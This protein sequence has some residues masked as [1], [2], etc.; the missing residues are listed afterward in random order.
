[1]EPPH[2]CEVELLNR[3]ETIIDQLYGFASWPPTILAWLSSTSKKPQP[4]LAELLE[5]SN[6]FGGSVTIGAVVVPGVVGGDGS[7]WD[8]L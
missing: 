7:T 8:T 6:T 3:S 5:H 1:M 4:H 2:E